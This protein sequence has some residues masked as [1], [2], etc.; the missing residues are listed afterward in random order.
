M[1]A[2]SFPFSCSLLF[3]WRG[4]VGMFG[5]FVM[6]VCNYLFKGRGG[7]DRGVW[8]GWIVCWWTGSVGYLDICM[9]RLRSWLGEWK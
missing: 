2:A 6:C 8:R 1:R 5:W 4:R 9:G 7:R 3:C